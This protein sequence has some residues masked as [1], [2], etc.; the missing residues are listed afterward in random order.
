MGAD[1]VLG[2]VRQ[3]LEVGMMVSAP[4]LAVALISGLIVGIF[5]A[6]TQINEATLSF[7][8]KAAAIFVT[9]AFVVWSYRDVANRHSDKVSGGAGDHQDSVH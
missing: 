2:L 7:I 3:G 9:L 1:Q 6:A 8:P 5:Q 4:L